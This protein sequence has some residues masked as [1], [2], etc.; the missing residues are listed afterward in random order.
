[1]K[2]KVCFFAII[3]CLCIIVCFSVLLLIYDHSTYYKYNDRFILGNTAE[4]IVARYGEFDFKVKPQENGKK[5][6]VDIIL[7]HIFIG[8]YFCL[9]HILRLTVFFGMKTEKHMM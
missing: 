7:N 4:N 3:I 1:M 2:K 5:V 8:M 6:I 9:I